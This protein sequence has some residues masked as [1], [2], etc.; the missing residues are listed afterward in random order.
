MVNGDK[1]RSKRGQNYSLDRATWYTHTNF[2]DMYDHN[3]EGTEVAR[4]A[5]RRDVPV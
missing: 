3:I 2:K 5:K 4:A 1:I